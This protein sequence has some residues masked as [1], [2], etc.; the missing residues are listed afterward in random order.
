VGPRWIDQLARSAVPPR[1][2]GLNKGSEQS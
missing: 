1:P 2:V